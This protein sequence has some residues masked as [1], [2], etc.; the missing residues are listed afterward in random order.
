[1]YSRKS[2]PAGNRSPL[3]NLSC[4]RPDR[5]GIGSSPVAE[6]TSVAVVIGLAGL[7]FEKTGLAL[8]TA[9][10]LDDFCSL[11]PLLLVETN[12]EKG[13]YQMSARPIRTRPERF[14]WAVFGI[15][16]LKRPFS[17]NKDRF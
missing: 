13:R 5:A 3:Q 12:G 1:M 11:G 10:A 14:W 2:L 16:A 15:L 6:T 9:L 8:W 4:R 17:L 7:A